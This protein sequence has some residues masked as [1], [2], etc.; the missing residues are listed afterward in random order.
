VYGDRRCVEDGVVPYR[1]PA[2]CNGCMREMAGVTPPNGRWVHLAGIDLVRDDRGTR[3]VLE[4]N[5]RTPSGLSYV[6]RNRA[7]MR[8]VFPEA[9]DGHRVM[10]VVPARYVSGRRFQPGRDEPGESH[11]RCD[12]RVPG[13]G[14][15]EFDPTHPD[16]NLDHHIRIGVGR[17]HSDV[18]PFPRHV[19]GGAHRA[20][21]RDR[22]G[23]GHRAAPRGVSRRGPVS[24]PR[25]SPPW[26][27]T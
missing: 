20:D 10:S 22:G 1:L 2:S 21:A 13:A 19:R 8:R 24:G 11:A 16:P 12:A 5:L 7:F 4:D 23:R 14:W 6:V 26:W 17:D 15:V 25:R 18:P 27:G 3:R 9:F